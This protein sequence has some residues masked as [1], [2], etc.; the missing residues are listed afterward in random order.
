MWKDSLLLQVTKR[1]NKLEGIAELFHLYKTK[2]KCDCEWVAESDMLCNKEIV[3][4]CKYAT[5]VNGK[6]EELLKLYEIIRIEYSKLYNAYTESQK[7]HEQERSEHNSLKC[8][9]VQVLN[10]YRILQKR[11]Y[12]AE[13][14]TNT[15]VVILCVCGCAAMI[16][17]CDNFECVR[18]A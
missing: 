13:A 2:P 1:D 7:H 3:E 11:F 16:L 4:L 9:C 14:S 8:K 15:L 12:K 17:M 18:N 10:K 5:S 6:Y